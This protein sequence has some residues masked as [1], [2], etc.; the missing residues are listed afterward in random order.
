MLKS[1]FLV[2]R[3]YALAFLLHG[4][5]VL[6]VFWMLTSWLHNGQWAAF[7]FQCTYFV[8]DLHTKVYLF[9]NPLQQQSW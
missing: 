4:F 3:R 2:L 9:P 5:T 1:L 6:K 8:G 7:Y